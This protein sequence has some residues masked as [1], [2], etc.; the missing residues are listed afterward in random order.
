VLNIV[1]VV[2]TNYTTYELLLYMHV[3]YNRLIDYTDYTRSREYV[4]YFWPKI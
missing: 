3:P 2:C 1:W 4:A